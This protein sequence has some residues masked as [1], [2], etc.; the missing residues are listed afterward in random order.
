MVAFDITDP[1]AREASAAKVLSEN[2]RL[3]VLI[4]NA[5]I[6]QRSLIKDTDFDVDRRVMEVD[7]F[8]PVALTLFVL[9]RFELNL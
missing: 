8:A 4:N 1:A 7:Y 3:D 2:D 6:G 9:A 5:G